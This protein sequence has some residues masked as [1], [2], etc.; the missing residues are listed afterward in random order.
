M[1]IVALSELKILY[2]AINFTVFA[3]VRL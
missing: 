2:C 3:M 1:E